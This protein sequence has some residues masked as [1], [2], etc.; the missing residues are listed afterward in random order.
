MYYMAIFSFSYIICVHLYR[1]YKENGIKDKSVF[2]VTE[3][4]KIS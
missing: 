3:F 4:D 1:V 2:N